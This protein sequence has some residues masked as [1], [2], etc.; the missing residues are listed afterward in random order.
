MKPF[1]K[2]PGGKSRELK[3]IMPM[4][5]TSYSR[6]VEPF[7]GGAALAFHLEKPALVSDINDNVTNIF[8]VVKDEKP[9]SQLI[10][11]INGTNISEGDVVK[12][13]EKIY[14]HYRDEEFGNTDP[15][16]KAYR[17]L[18]LR[19]LGFS[20]MYR[21]NTKTGKSN[22]PFGWY[23]KFQTKLDR[24]YH[25][26]LQSWNIKCQSF[27]RTLAEV[28]VDDF[29]FLDPPYYERNSGYGTSSNAGTSE[30][31]HVTLHDKLKDI[32]ASWLLI[33]SDCELYRDLYKDFNIVEVDFFY[34]QNF[35]G[36][37]NKKSAVKHLY[38][39]N[40]N[41]KSSLLNF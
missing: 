21:V 4:L 6:V 17:F 18:L 12:H 8:Y 14:Y 22:V 23:G 16:T 31:L 25:E 1:F 7:A 41:N 24:S 15:V 27:E 13:L 38:I 30:D 20:G 32:S 26:L 3:H 33:H 2:Y 29:I 36:R 9:F 19:Q 39:T 37:D 28:L 5:P 11:L 10:E 40:Y 34:S 35:K